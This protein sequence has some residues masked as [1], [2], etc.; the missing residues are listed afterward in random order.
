MVASVATTAALYHMDQ[1]AGATQ[2]KEEALR[3]GRQISAQAEGLY[4]YARQ[5]EERDPTGWLISYLAQGVDPRVMKIVRWD[6]GDT[7]LADATVQSENYFY[8]SDKHLFEYLKR[9]SHEEPVGIKIQIDLP[10]RGF[11]GSASKARNDLSVAIVFAAVLSLVLSL[12]ARLTRRESEEP[13][14]A[15]QSSEVETSAQ[16]SLNPALIQEWIKDAR[17]VLTALSGQV[18]DVLK[19]A[20]NLA[21]NASQSYEA[22]RKLREGLHHELNE[23]HQGRKMMKEFEAHAVKCEAIVLN[24]LI[25]ASRKGPAGN[26]FLKA[27][28]EIHQVLKL[29]RARA[30]AAEKAFGRLEVDMEPITTDADIAFHSYRDFFKTTR[31]MDAHIQSTSASIMSQAE[32]IRALGEKNSRSV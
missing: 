10:Y 21:M 16:P 23:I 30:Q 22:T 8:Y 19:D 17:S 26:S 1:A 11:L 5:K 7:E 24:M 27:G 9:L 20:K 12:R 18:R 31:A 4:L 13:A 6:F 28:D 15:Y 29:M 14:V 3:W 25:D 32:L 2:H